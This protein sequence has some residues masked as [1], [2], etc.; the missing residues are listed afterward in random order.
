MGNDSRI[1]VTYTTNAGSTREVAE[2]IAAKLQ[3]GD[4]QADVAEAGAVQ[5]LAG[6]SGLVIGG[7]MIM[8]WHRKARK[9]LRKH[10]EALQ[11]LPYHVYMTAMKVT[12]ST[13]DSRITIDESI[14]EEAGDPHKLSFREKYTTAA[15]Y[16]EPVFGTTTIPEPRSVAL[17]GGKLDY[18][19]L[20]FPQMLFVMLVISARP[21]DRRN[22]EL[23]DGWAAGLAF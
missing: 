8:G 15:H 22:W 5:S 7:P 9:F 6:Y 10:R 19:K 18:T 23:I 17:L 12:G 4:C 16:V 14:R 3:S 21:T 13:E 11:T 1:L 20:K 2:R